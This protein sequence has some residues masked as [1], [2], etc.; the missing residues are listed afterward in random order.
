MNLAQ[1]TLVSKFEADGHVSIDGLL[2]HHLLDEISVAVK[3]LFSGKRDQRPPQFENKNLDTEYW[4]ESLIQ[5]NFASFCCK[6]LRKL[7]FNQQLAEIAKELL[8]TSSVRL[9]NDMVIAKRPSPNSMKKGVI[10]WHRDRQYWRTC[11]SRNMVTAWIPLADCGPEN[12]SIE[13]LAGSHRWEQ[14]HEGL[15][16]YQE[17]RSGIEF[18]I[19]S[20]GRKIERTATTLRKGSVSFHG[21]RL[22]H[23]SGPNVSSTERIVVAIHY[24]PEDN[25]WVRATRANGELIQHEVDLLVR[26]ND[27]GDPDYSDPE[28]CP[29][30][31]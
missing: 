13:F 25:H 27:A 19:A 17:D 14:S 29:T 16:F 18:R 5:V 24:Q 1:P 26:R 30:I 9:W 7:V 10:G 3:D 22:I 20:S 11:G 31:L 15:D 6:R 21:C 8:E 28:I 12:G 23:G 4:S 2:D